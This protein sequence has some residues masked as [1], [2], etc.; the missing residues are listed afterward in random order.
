MNFQNLSTMVIRLIMSLLLVFIMFFSPTVF[1]QDASTLL[2]THPRP[3]FDSAYS[4]DAPGAKGQ[5]YSLFEDFFPAVIRF[6][7]QI[8]G[9][10]M[11]G[12]LVYAG[13]L[14]VISGANE[15]Y[16]EKAKMLFYGVIIGAT[17]ISLA[18]AL[19]YGI[20][21]LNLTSAPSNTATSPI[22]PQ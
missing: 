17:V 9:A 21:Q 7:L 20:T 16:R 5:T 19:V 6:S 3:E 1:A 12:F 2:P 15:P 14:Y 22:T 18:Y 10:V 13:I 11:L 8:V 4:K